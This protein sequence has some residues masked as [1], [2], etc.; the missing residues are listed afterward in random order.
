VDLCRQPAEAQAAAC[1][2]GQAQGLQ[3]AMAIGICFF[4]WAA[5]HFFLAARTLRRDTV[6]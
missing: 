6:S 5:I 2:L 1:A 4:V 3:Q